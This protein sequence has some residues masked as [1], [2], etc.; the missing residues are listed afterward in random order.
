MDL[1][2]VM[3]RVTSTGL[4]AEQVRPRVN[5][6]REE[7]RVSLCVLICRLSL[8]LTNGYPQLSLTNAHGSIACTLVA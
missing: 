2:P 1:K 5:R 3:P 4:G 8:F 7:S 6:F